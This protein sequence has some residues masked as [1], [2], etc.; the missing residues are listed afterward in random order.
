MLIPFLKPAL[1]I[2]GGRSNYVNPEDEPL[3]RALFPQVEFQTIA[4]AGHWLHA[5]APEEFL[6]RLLAFL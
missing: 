4:E 5:D 6:R 1:F 3:I 2:R